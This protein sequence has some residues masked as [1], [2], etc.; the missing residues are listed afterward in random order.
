M[1]SPSLTQVSGNA[2]VG[3][4]PNTRGRRRQR[5][6]N[7]ETLAEQPRAKRQRKPLSEQTFVNPEATLETYEVK[8]ARP[9]IELKQD[10]L[11]N[12][13]EVKKEL[14]LRSKKPKTGERIHKG[15]G[16]VVLTSNN[17]FIVS[18]LP[19]LPDRLRTDATS[20]QHGTIDPL[21]GYALN[22]SQTH[23][24][25]WP[26]SAPTPSPESFVFTLPYPA[27]NSTDPLPLG[28][29][30]APSASSSEPG[31]VVVIPTSGK[32]TYWESISSATTL[33]FMRQQRTG[34]EDSIPG[35]FSGETV[36]QIVNAESAAGFI[37][38]FSSG[39]LAHMSVRDAHGRPKISVQ[40]LRT[41]LGPSVGGL[42]GSIRQVLSHAAQGDIAA[43]RSDRPLKQGERTIVAATSKGKL[44]AWR[45]HRG[46]HHDLLTEFD[47][48]EPIIQAIQDRDLSASKYPIE[49][50]KIMDF[51]FVP[52]VLD[53]RYSEMS[54]LR[55]GPQSADFQHLLLLT[56]FT[57]KNI[58]RYNLVEVLLPNGA[59]TE[60]AIVVGMVRPI[61]NYSTPPDVHALAKPRLYL[62]RPSVVAFLVFDRAAVIASIARAPDSPDSQLM[63]DNHILPPTYEDVVDLRDDP[64]LEI[65]GS[66]VEEPQLPGSEEARTHRIK[67]KNPSAVFLVRGAGTL[68]ATTTDAE[69][70][71]SEKPPKITAKSKLEQAVFFGIKEGNPLVFDVPRE[72]PFSD[73]EIGDAALELSSDILTSNSPHLTALAPHLENNMQMRV[74]ALDK[75]MSHLRSLK[76]D[77]SRN[78]RW[79]LLWNAEKLQAAR[80]IWQ[81]HEHFINNRPGDAKK[82]L[83]AEVVEFIRNEEKAPRDVA[84]GE[85]DQLRHFFVHDAHRMNLF[86]AWAY[87]VV[88]Y[89]A[90]ANLDQ[91]SLT[92]LVYEAIEINNGALR[93]AMAFRK[94][95]LALYGLQGEKMA[96]GILSD[97]YTGLPAPWTADQYITNNLKRLVEL[98]SEWAK[99]NYLPNSPNTPEQV[100]IQRI[101]ALL[102]PT[103]EVYLTAVQELSRWALASENPKY[104]TI[105]QTFQATYEADRHD[106]VVLLAQTAN[107]DAA[108]K[109]AEEHRSLAALA[110]ILTSQID[111]YRKKLEVGGLS[112]EETAHLEDLMEAK[113]RQVRDSFD[114]YGK[115]FAF[116]F[117]EHLIR[118]FGIDAVL[119]YAGDKLYKTSYLRTKPELA[120]VSWINDII[121]EEDILHAAETL[122][123][124]G[125]AREQQVWNKK[126]EL[127]LGKLARM[128]E[129]SRPTSKASASIQEATVNESV[130][131]ASVDAIDKEL[132]IIK[133]QDQLYGQIRPVVSVAIDESAEL[134]MAIEEFP[135]KVPKKYKI[136]SEI[137]E[138]GLGRLLRHEA[139]DPL[140]LIDLLTLI[141]LKPELKELI[142]DQFF[143][144]IEVA[145]YGLSGSERDQAERLIWRRCYLREDWTRINNTSLKGDNDIM[146]V[147][148]TT[149]LFPVFCVLYANQQSGIDG[150]PYRRVMPSEALG[151]Y[152]DTLDKRFK[153]LDK[154]YREKLLEAMRWEDKNLK[155][156]IEKHRLEQWARDTRKLAEDAVDHQYDQKTEEGAASQSPVPSRG[157]GASNG[158]EANGIH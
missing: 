144:A 125:L 121:G 88:K 29:L 61:Y 49:S 100:L 55:Q 82:D 122:L 51:S 104:V 64:T 123:N 14:S 117:Y 50:F 73:N 127:S 13:P 43:V 110:D 147:L 115:A 129:A 1:F 59:S 99:E 86:L 130:A 148:G 17:A 67:A 75:L 31:L 156:H 95:H 48:R 72:L 103:I 158:I 24:V 132:A 11:E 9:S 134:P 39:R 87:E 151:V 10:G 97:N 2:S 126:I 40:F 18:K 143:L 109:I 77:L 146:E 36:I 145:N 28:S 135:V 38:V 65:V 139:L 138:D 89:N 25:V 8:S 71:A 131:D 107:W 7:T 152:T 119:E 137:F 94:T 21:T 19:A 30:I 47:A 106:K 3:A 81:K 53:S 128:A 46:G 27:K 16:S 118:V 54:Q 56:S 157:Y 60:S 20:R 113:E 68:R 37:L 22:L 76:V 34:V 149:D 92:R 102:P 112:S 62:P 93:D 45:I 35:M 84:R 150:K 23:A 79:E 15:D 114:K 85:V 124:I 105:G 108:I 5:P 32:I 90:K 4:T 111:S 42:F 66:G 44:H 120:K 155:T 91:A 154:A 101:R 12:P 83:V 41:S 63:E 136:L 69:R 70:F 133:I 153:N 78:T 6:A 141:Q 98:A 58:C 116:P 26:Y 57:G 140:T 96:N 142:P 74:R 33:D 80:F 52:S